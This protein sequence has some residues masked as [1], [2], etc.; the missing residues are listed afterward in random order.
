MARW[1]AAKRVGAV[2]PLLVGQ[3]FVGGILHDGLMLPAQGCGL[4]P[5]DPLLVGLHLA[6]PALGACL[7]DD[8]ELLVDREVVPVRPWLSA[9]LLGFV[10]DLLVALAEGP[11]D[12][13]PGSR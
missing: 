6:E 13:L 10:Q 11:A 12:R 7:L 5:P 2:E 4:F 8:V 3:A 9:K 1:R